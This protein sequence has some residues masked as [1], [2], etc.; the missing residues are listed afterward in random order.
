MSFTPPFKRYAA[1]H[2]EQKGQHYRAEADPRKQLRED[3][4][5]RVTA[6]QGQSVRRQCEGPCC[7]H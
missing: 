1:S 7:R 2:A 5:L 4:V 3:A 6:R